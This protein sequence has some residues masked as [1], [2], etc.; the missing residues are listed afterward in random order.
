MGDTPATALLNFVMAGNAIAEAL[1]DQ[2]DMPL[3]PDKASVIATDIDLAKRGAK[4][5][6]DKGG[7]PAHEVRRLGVDHSLSS[8]KRKRGNPEEKD[9]HGKEQGK[10][11]PEAPDT[12][13]P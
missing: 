13:S 7:A 1:E 4:A 6:G 12:D 5:L 10:S 8:K 2:L 3:A 11:L 9:E